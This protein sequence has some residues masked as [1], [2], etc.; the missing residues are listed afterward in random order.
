MGARRAHGYDAAVLGARAAF[1][2]GI[3]GTSNFAAAMKHNIPMI[4]PMTHSWVQMFESENE[5]FSVY[6]REHSKDAI[7]N[8]YTYDT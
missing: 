3:D 2:G 5:A 1:I 6:L 8:S 4:S 7:L